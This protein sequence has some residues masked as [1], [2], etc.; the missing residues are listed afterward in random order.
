M[1]FLIPLLIIIFG[2]SW[3]LSKNIINGILY[4]IPDGINIIALNPMEVFSVS[5]SISF[6]LTILFFLP[7]L[8][9]K[10]MKYIS[11]AL[12]NEEKQLIKNILIGGTFLFLLGFILSFI[13]FVY[14]GLNWF[15]N[16]NIEYGFETLW[17]LSKTINTILS[18]SFISGLIFE[19]PIIL[20]YLLKNK[21]INIELEHKNRLI[22]LLI[23][24]LGI[25]FITPDGSFFSQIFLGIPIYLLIELSIFLGNRN[26]KV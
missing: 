23:L 1:K 7:Y 13:G 9:F 6:L 19:I 8:L 22:L 20:Y 18:V 21:L 17:S 10:G 11:P 4:F 26:R 24:F 14:Y 16:F 2:M 25:A 5:L 3:K 12:Y 15:A